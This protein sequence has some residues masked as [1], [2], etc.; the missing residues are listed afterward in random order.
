MKAKDVY[1]IS[2]DQATKLTGYCIW[3]NG[4]YKTHGLIDFHKEKDSN[5]RMELMFN[6]I[7]DLFKGYMSNLTVSFE[8]TQYQM[9]A[10]SFKQL[11]RLQGALIGLCMIYHI[12]FFIVS[13]ST[14]RH[15]LK[16]GK[17]KQEAID[18][19]AENLELTAGSDESDAIC[20]GQAVMYMYS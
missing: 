6:A 14:W 10:E 1:H 20:I 17:T 18:Y 12:P 5:K 15:V 19:I 2:F 16:I 13:P 11:T 9:N 3:I 4:K 7:K 8:D